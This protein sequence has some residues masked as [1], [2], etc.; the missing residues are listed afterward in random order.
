MKD[1]DSVEHHITLVC[2]AVQTKCS[3]VGIKLLCALSSVKQACGQRFRRPNTPGVATVTERPTQPKVGL[4]VGLNVQWRQTDISTTT[5]TTT[6]VVLYR[7]A[8]MEN[9]IITALDRV[10]PY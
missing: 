2:V 9:T 8:T 1:P 6:I 5:T 4:G 10:K 3:R 7:L